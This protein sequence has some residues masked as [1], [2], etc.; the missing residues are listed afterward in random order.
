MILVVALGAMWLA[1]LGPGY[2]RRRKERSRDGVTSVSVFHRQLRVLQRS[3]PAPLPPAYRLRALP[4]DT[5]SGQD[6]V[7]TEGLIEPTERPVLTVVGADRLPRP[8][9]AFLG[10]PDPAGERG[11]RASGARDDG[12]EPGDADWAGAAGPED[13]RWRGDLP[14]R[15][16]RHR[17]VAADVDAYTS[18]R[19]CKRRRD[20]FVALVSTVFG[21]LVLGV[22]P[23]AHLLWIVTA[24]AA[25]ALGGYVALL[26]HMRMVADERDRKLRYLP[27]PAERY[28]G[29]GYS[30]A[31]YG[32]RRAG[33]A[34]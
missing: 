4:A 1:V 8:L 23:G 13:S 28:D 31:A 25:V 17:P 2:L 10:D 11:G 15:S 22:I 18:A 32:G 34:R 27:P 26:V 5:A 24:L 21:T 30:E 16:G 19:A 7:C 14:G 12:D 9:L 29:Q 33:S 3:G 20:V 6:G